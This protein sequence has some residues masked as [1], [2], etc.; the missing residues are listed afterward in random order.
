M[1]KCWE[2]RLGDKGRLLTFGDFFFFLFPFFNQKNCLYWSSCVRDF[3]LFTLS[4]PH[5]HFFHL[6][7]MTFR[8]SFF[9]LSSSTYMCDNS[10]FFSTFPFLSFLL[11]LLF[12]FLLLVCVGE[13]FSHSYPHIHI[14]TFFF[15]SFHIQHLVLPL[16]PFLFLPPPMC[17]TFP[18]F[19]FFPPP[20][21]SFFYRKNVP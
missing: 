21:P 16:F 14:Y 6:L 13:F 9:T 7:F 8:S 3:F 19:L 20:F 2:W 17:V 1:A 15:L 10:F 5:T 11:L 4:Y 12:L 18:S